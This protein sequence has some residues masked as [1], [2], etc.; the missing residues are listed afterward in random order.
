MIMSNFKVYAIVIL[1]LVISCTK[2]EEQ[3]AEEIVVTIADKTITANVFKQRAEYTIRPDIFADKT[4]VLNN[5]IAEK[6]LAL[7]GEKNADIAEQEYLLIF[8]K[9]IR[10]QAMRERLYYNDVYYQTTIDEA[11]ID[12]VMP[13]SSRTYELEFYNIGNKNLADSL[14]DAIVERLQLLILSRNTPFIGRI[15]ILI[16]FMMPYLAIL[17]PRIRLSGHFNWKIIPI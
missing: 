17:L 11:E 6:L 7:E 16:S 10:E 13:L 15:R 9:G 2:K 12:H 3:Q 1:L 14:A 4:I 8:T 5:L